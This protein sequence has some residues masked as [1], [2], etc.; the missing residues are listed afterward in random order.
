MVRR[1]VPMRWPRCLCSCRRRLLSITRQP[2]ARVC[3]LEGDVCEYV[4]FVETEA[5][6]VAR[7]CRVPIRAHRAASALAARAATFASI[8][9]AAT[10]CSATVRLTS[11]QAVSSSLAD[12]LNEDASNMIT[13]FDVLRRQSWCSL[14]ALA[15]MASILGCVATMSGCS[16]SGQASDAASDG[17]VTNATN[18][19]AALAC[20][21]TASCAFDCEGN[22]GNQAGSGGFPRIACSCTNGSFACNIMYEGN[23]GGSPAPV[24]RISPGA[25]RLAVS[26]RRAAM[27]EPRSASAPRRANGSAPE[28]S[29]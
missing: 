25:A 12:N 1:I 13:L 15:V 17:S 11:C 28:I 26:A 24:L 16:G 18:C 9:S 2:A 6:G 8:C 19:H 23:G 10:S 3:A 14:L 4:V 21:G 22:T 7:R 5:G 27:P 29:R 20:S